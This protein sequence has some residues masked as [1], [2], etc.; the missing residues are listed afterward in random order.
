MQQE[1]SDFFSYRPIA[2]ENIKNPQRLAG[3]FLL[4]EILSNFLQKK[5]HEIE[6]KRSQTGKPELCENWCK[7]NKLSK[8]NFNSSH[9]EDLV[10]VAVSQKHPVGIDVEIHR[11]DRDFEKIQKR[12]FSAKEKMA[13]QQLSPADKGPFFYKLWTLKES[14]VKAHGIGLQMGLNRVERNE[15]TPSKQIF[16]NHP[17]SNPLGGNPLYEKSNPHRYSLALSIVPER[18][19]VNLS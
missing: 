16:L 19:Q 6:L 17:A 15:K 10:A 9:S 1:C 13:W 7:E 11:A 4:R 8:L 2:K 12:V 14:L 3:R 5:A 18:G